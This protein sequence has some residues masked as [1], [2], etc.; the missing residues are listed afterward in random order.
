MNNLLWMDATMDDPL[1]VDL[2]FD[3]METFLPDDWRE[4]AKELGALKR[5]RNIPDAETLL[6]EAQNSNTSF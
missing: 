6:F 3:F 1:V 5:C 4:K 2:D